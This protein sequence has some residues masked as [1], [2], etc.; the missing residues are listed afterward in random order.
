ML[1]LD[2]AGKTTVLH[3]L[4]LG[5]VRST[6]PTLGFNVESVSYKNVNFTVWYVGGQEKLRTLWRHYYEGTDA[7]IFVIDSNDPQRVKL[8]KEEL[9]KIL[10]EDTMTDAV[11][12]VLANKQ[13]LPNALSPSEMREAL[14]LGRGHPQKSWYI[15]G[16]CAANGSGLYEGLDWLS[17]EL[18]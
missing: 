6:A 11:V 12:L 9:M 5:E 14:S 16:C 4:K 1:G 17:K 13:D 7:L 8:A 3:L 15:Q 18:Q 2:A 10:D